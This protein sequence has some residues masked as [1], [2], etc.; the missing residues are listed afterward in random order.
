M[1]DSET[2][3]EVPIDIS[4]EVMSGSIHVKEC[5]RTFVNQLVLKNKQMIQG[6]FSSFDDA[7]GYIRKQL[8]IQTDQ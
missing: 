7:L 1:V 2:K 4:D 6:V 3:P 5:G 8:A